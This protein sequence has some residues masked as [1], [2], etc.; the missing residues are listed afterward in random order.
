MCI[1]RKEPICEAESE[2][3]PHLA[4]GKWAIEQMLA[5]L[6][7][8]LQRHLPSRTVEPAKLS[9]SLT[10]AMWRAGE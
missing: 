7:L 8:V 4:F 3:S 6:P 5:P 9:P 1:H 2:T 10:R